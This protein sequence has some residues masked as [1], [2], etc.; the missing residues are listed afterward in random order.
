[1]FFVLH[2]WTKHLSTKSFVFERLT[3][4]QQRKREEEVNR[5]SREEFE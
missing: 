4:S 3:D 1:M 2:S 5:I